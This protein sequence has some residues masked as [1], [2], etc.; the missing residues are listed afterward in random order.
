MG[1]WLIG[2]KNILNPIWFVFND[3][4]QNPIQIGEGCLVEIKIK[5]VGD[6]KVKKLVTGVNSG[7]VKCKVQF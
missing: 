2:I 3:L 6:G 5:T 1:V 4:R 7:L